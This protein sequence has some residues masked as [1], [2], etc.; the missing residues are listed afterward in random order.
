MAII[1]IDQSTNIKEK[2]FKNYIND[3]IA[4]TQYQTDNLESI[5]EEAPNIL[6]GYENFRQILRAIKRGDT[7]ANAINKF[8]GQSCPPKTDSDDNCESIS[9]NDCW[10]EYCL[11]YLELISKNNAVDK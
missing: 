10:R 9:C 5:I 2:K 7:F 6:K 1:K 4:D 11:H 8:A 3:I